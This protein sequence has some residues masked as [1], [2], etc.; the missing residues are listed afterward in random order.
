MNAWFNFWDQSYR[1]EVWIDIRKISSFVFC[2]DHGYIVCYVVVGRTEF[3]LDSDDAIRLRHILRYL[4]HGTESAWNEHFSGESEL[5]LVDD[6][7]WECL[8]LK[9]QKT[10]AQKGKKGKKATH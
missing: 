2:A 10:K 7:A 5:I 9:V 4:G 3:V 6:E 8:Q 1:R